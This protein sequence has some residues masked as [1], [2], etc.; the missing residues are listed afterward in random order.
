M[1][2]KIQ[3]TKKVAHGVTKA[4]AIS[5]P[6]FGTLKGKAFSTLQ[7]KVYHGQ[8]IAKVQSDMYKQDKYAAVVDKKKK[9]IEAAQIAAQ[10]KIDAQT[11]KLDSSTTRTTSAANIAKL[12]KK[13]GEAVA[14]IESKLAQNVAKKKKDMALAETK[15]E[16]YN[17]A[18]AKTSAAIIESIQKKDASYNSAGKSLSQILA[19]SKDAYQAQAEKKAADLKKPLQEAVAKKLVIDTKVSKTEE[20]YKQAMIKLASNPKDATLQ[21]EVAKT[22][23][24]YSIAQALYKSPNYQVLKKNIATAAQ[25]LQTAQKTNK[26]SE[27]SLTA[28]QL[29]KMV[30]GDSAMNKQR[31]EIKANV[32]ARTQELITLGTRGSSSKLLELRQKMQK[33]EYQDK[34]Q[35]RVRALET[36]EKKIKEIKNTKTPYV[37]TADNRI[38]L[39]KG[40]KARALQ[41]LASASSNNITKLLTNN[42]IKSTTP[43]ITST[44]II[45]TAQNSQKN[46]LANA[47]KTVTEASA[48]EANTKV[49]AATAAKTAANALKSRFYTTYSGRAQKR[50]EAANA[51]AAA[52]TLKVT[53]N[54]IKTT[55]ATTNEGIKA[56]SRANQATFNAAQKTLEAEK[57]KTASVIGAR[58]RQKALGKAKA[59]QAAKVVAAQAAVQAAQAV[60]QARRKNVASSITTNPQL[61]VNAQKTQVIA[62]APSKAPSKTNKTLKINA[63]VQQAQK[64]AKETAT[65]AGTNIT[66][67]E[68]KQVGRKAAQTILTSEAVKKL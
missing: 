39:A 2:V 34:I 14:Q 56:K 1:S 41:K 16:G 50:A 52:K 45:R 13:T 66:S 27:L 31:K 49:E 38:I 5:Q 33:P 68:L 57:G 47:T 61:Q 59:E 23:S 19:N 28:N 43:G 22:K 9:A 18:A 3:K 36:L 65:A 60:V 12:T 58:F 26:L 67:K 11:K 55:A 37:F 48:A 51:L 64:Q 53:A 63:A 30:Q 25:N 6:V 7:E 35:S 44:N 29:V 21:A 62:Q 15:K 20:A 54:Q 10:T 32:A 42:V 40:K 4:A 8:N 24:E 17:A 46:A